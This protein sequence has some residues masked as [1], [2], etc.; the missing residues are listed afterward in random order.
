M[1]LKA[2]LYY[3]WIFSVIIFAIYSVLNKDI[4]NVSNLVEFFKENSKYMLLLFTIISCI[5]GFF[6]IPSTPFIFAGV[7]LFPSNLWEV[8]IISILSI[9]LT[10]FLIYFFSDA[11]GFSK[12]LENNAKGFY[13]KTRNILSNR[14][15]TLLISLWAFFPA[16]PTDLVTYIG[17][18]TKSSFAKIFT[19]VF[20]GEAILVFAYVFGF[21]SIMQYLDGVF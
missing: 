20:I 15:S 18:I 11:L 9:M 13:S 6:L 8:Y 17:G 14:Y 19:G 7:I 4:L 16:V 3:T 5:R 10:T 2:L 21:N 12:K 1:S